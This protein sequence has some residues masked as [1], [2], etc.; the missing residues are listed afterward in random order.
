MNRTFFRITSDPRHEDLE[1]VSFGPLEGRL[2]DDWV[3][4]G[5]GIFDLDPGLEVFLKNKFGTEEGG[6][7]LPTEEWAALSLMHDV[8]AI[9]I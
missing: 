5:F 1:L 7:R 9:V 2:F 6:V 3:M 8:G 4:K